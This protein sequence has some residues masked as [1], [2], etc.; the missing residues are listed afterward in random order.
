MARVRLTPKKQ[1]FFSLYADA[2]ANTVE[3][4]RLLVSCSSASRRTATA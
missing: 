3:I 4:S 1:E 2:S